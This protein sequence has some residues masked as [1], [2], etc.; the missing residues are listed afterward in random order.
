[1]QDLTE[2]ACFDEDAQ[3]FRRIIAHG[4]EW[5]NSRLIHQG[6][7]QRVRVEVRKI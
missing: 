3:G 4:D 1:M 6:V 5:M 7:E 2:G